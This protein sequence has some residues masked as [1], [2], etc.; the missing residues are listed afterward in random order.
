MI[1][2]VGNNTAINL[3]YVTDVKH[4]WLENFY[5]VFLVHGNHYKIRDDHMSFDEF[6]QK[7]E[8]NKDAM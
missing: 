5:M 2:K 7:L 4:D 3:D 1:L 8:E 6:I